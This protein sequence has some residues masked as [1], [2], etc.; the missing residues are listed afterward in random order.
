MKRKKRRTITCEFC[1]DYQ[2]TPSKYRNE[3]GRKCPYKKEYVN[4]TNPAC[5]TFLLVKW[6]WCI[7]NKYFIDVEACLNRQRIHLPDCKKCSPGKLLV[8]Y[9]KE[10]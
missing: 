9:M 7:K 10:K 8:T 4:G 5:E 2:N 1:N 6:F 3:E